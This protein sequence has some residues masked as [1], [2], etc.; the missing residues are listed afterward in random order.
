VHFC[1]CRT[2]EEAACG[3]DSRAYEIACGRNADP[4]P[5][6]SGL[7]CVS[8]LHSVLPF[9][10]AIVYLPLRGSI[11][12]ALGSMVVWADVAFGGVA[13]NFGAATSRKVIGMRARNP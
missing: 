7:H 12:A 3:L 4:R 2:A 6:R 5:Q 1:I 13:G 10:G 9:Q 11:D 8:A